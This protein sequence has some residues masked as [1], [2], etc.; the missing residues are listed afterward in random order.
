[1]ILLLFYD[2]DFCYDFLIDSQGY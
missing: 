1:M 2:I